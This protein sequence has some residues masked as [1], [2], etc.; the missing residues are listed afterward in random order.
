[1]KKAIHH[2]FPVGERREKTIHLFTLI[3]LLVVIAIIAIL[4]GMLLPAL[5]QARGRARTTSCINNTK[6]IISGIV[7]Y[8][9]DF[10]DV[11]PATIKSVTGSEEPRSLS[12]NS[13]GALKNVGLGIVAA[14]GYLGKGSGGYANRVI[15]D[16]RPEVLQCP[17]QPEDGWNQMYGN[18]CDYLYHRDSGTQIQWSFPSFGKKLGGLKREMITIC[19]TA[20]RGLDTVP[21]GHSGECTVIS[22]ADGSAGTCSYNVYRDGSNNWERGQLIDAAN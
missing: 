9:G 11:L 16:N 19:M 3:E 13:G 14:G 6:Q 15:G 10:H 22:R 4:A 12:E 17:S 18:W 8:A 7:M 5:N 21:P 1:M 20:G 2:H